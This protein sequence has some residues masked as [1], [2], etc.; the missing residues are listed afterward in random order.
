MDNEIDR[1][2]REHGSTVE[3]EQVKAKQIDQLEKQL[4]QLTNEKAKHEKALQ[5][6]L[7]AVQGELTTLKN[8]TEEQIH[9]MTEQVKI[10]R[11]QLPRSTGPYVHDFGPLPACSCAVYAKRDIPSRLAAQKSPVEEPDP[12]PRPGQS[13]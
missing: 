5:D 4:T 8:A 9:S 13:Q 2:S 12:D 1:L 6:E 10:C 11:R 3:K 7:N